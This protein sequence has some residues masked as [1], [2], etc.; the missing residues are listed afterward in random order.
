[1][2]KVPIFVYIPGREA[3]RCV[4]AHLAIGSQQSRPAAGPAQ[5]VL[6]LC[7]RSG[8]AGY[9]V[10]QKYGEKYEKASSG[11]RRKAVRLLYSGSNHYDLLLKR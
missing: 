5:L 2:L 7:C 8:R 6:C 1:M 10:I 4:S 9:V 11:K 3:G